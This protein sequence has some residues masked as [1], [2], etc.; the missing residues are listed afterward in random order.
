MD[1][2]MPGCTGI[3]AAQVIRQ[4]PAYLNIPIVYLSAE[5]DLAQQMAALRVG[6]DDFLNKTISDDHLLD[7]VAIRVERF[8]TLSNLMGRD[9][10]TGLHNH[11]ALKL[12]LESEL[13]HAQRVHATTV[14]AMLDID[15]FKSVNDRFG[16]PVG[17][18][19]IKSLARLLT[20]RLRKSD[21]VGRYGGEEFAVILRDT[22]PARALALL[23]EL[24]T[25]F[26]EV[27]HSHGGQ[28]FN[29]SFSAGIAH[30]PPHRGMEAL[31]AAADQALYR[32]KADGRNRVVRAVN[33]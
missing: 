22:D 4:N 24:R 20:Q 23:D 27:A 15:H 17:D 1:L 25:R 30:A 18:A 26:A 12:A 31:I 11:I 21:I 13:E 19:V 9:S 14:F 8:R 2:Y 16:H 10:L 6:G 28:T 29:A 5:T 33:G 32:A 3:E 7:A